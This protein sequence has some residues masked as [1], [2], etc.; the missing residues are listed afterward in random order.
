MKSLKINENCLPPKRYDHG[1]T[2][3]NKDKVYLFGGLNSHSTSLND[4]WELTYNM[5]I[6]KWKKIITSNSIPKRSEHG[7]L[8][9]DNKLYV[10]GGYGS[11]DSMLD[12][13]RCLDLTNNKLCWNKIK[14]KKML[15]MYAFSYD[16][17]EN[18]I[19]IFGGVNDFYQSNE[20][21]CIDINKREMNKIDIIK[22]NIC[23]PERQN[24]ASCILHEKLYIFGG[25]GIFDSKLYYIDLKN[26]YQLGFIQ[27]SI[28][29]RYDFSM[30]SHNN[31][32]GIYI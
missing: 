16:L 10:F 23:I 6:L 8:F 7:F 3:N 15:C 13:F 31:K 4:L 28:L 19:L 11:N 29:W 25:A 5:D 30:I 2:T 17:Y 21:Y 20:L 12:D 22:N 9:N 1:I 18:K 24:H 14:I 27:T 26:G 32:F